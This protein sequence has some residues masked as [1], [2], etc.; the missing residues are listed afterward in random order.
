[1]E[2]SSG[3]VLVLTSRDAELLVSLAHL[4]GHDPDGQVDADRHG[5]G[6]ACPVRP[7]R[8][9][10]P[11]PPRSGRAKYVNSARACMRSR[12]RIT[13]GAVALGQPG[14]AR[15]ISDAGLR[16]SDIFIMFVLDWP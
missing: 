4:G 6:H 16:R 14:L 1:M 13:T 12:R 7:G 2:I 10:R 11:C 9:G 15:T 3:V 5:L 8:S